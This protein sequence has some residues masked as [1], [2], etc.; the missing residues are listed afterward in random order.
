[1]VTVAAIALEGAFV[2]IAMMNAA[3]L[4]LSSLV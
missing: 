1:M 4:N 2:P 3:A